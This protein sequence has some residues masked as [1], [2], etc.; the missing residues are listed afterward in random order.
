MEGVGKSIGGGSR[1][2]FYEISLY[3]VLTGESVL[4]RLVWPSC[5]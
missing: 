3:G 5:Q 2:S 4:L 1:L